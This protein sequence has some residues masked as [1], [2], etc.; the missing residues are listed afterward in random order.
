LEGRKLKK[1][2]LSKPGKDHHS[3]QNLD[4]T[5]LLP[6]TGKLFEKV[7]LKNNPKARLRSA[8]Q[9]LYA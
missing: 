8:S 4:P 2:T 7:I 3:P 9:V 5:R 1:G 6:M